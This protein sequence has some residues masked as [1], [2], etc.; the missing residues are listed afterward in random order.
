SPLSFYFLWYSLGLG[1]SAVYIASVIASGEVIHFVIGDVPPGN[2][3][4]AYVIYLGGSVALHIGL[5][6][7]R[8]VSPNGKEANVADL[9]SNRLGGLIILWAIGLGALCAP[10]WIAYLGAPGRLLQWAPLASLS[11]FAL[12]PRQRFRLTQTAFI[13]L[14]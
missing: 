10:T 9:C 11:A 2:I 3:A 14:L 4:V 12:T 8:P 13:I 7:F 5:E 6:I 1:L